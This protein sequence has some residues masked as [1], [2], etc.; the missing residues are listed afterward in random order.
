MKRLLNTCL[1]ILILAGVAT[2][3]SLQERGTPYSAFDDNN[4]TIPV[5]V[6]NNDT[7]ALDTTTP[8]RTLLNDTNIYLETVRVAVRDNQDWRLT[9]LHKS[10]RFDRTDT[11]VNAVTFRQ[12]YDTAQGQFTLSA[13]I[14]VYASNA[15]DTLGY[16]L[17]YTP[18]HSEY[19]D[20][21]TIKA[22]RPLGL[23]VALIRG[24]TIKYKVRE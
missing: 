14:G 3:Q 2:A 4:R 18:I 21:I 13:G 20:Q 11:V 1:M 12:M 19:Y 10:T 24:Y 6:F 15:S 7:L 23:G 9:I 8:T 5:F 17:E 16:T 22:E